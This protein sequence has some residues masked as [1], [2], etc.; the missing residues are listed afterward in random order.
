MLWF[1]V[2]F[3]LKL[4]TLCPE[5]LLLMHRPHLGNLLSCVVRGP[6]GDGRAGGLDGAQRTVCVGEVGRG[7]AGRTRREGEMGATGKEGARRGGDRECYW[8]LQHGACR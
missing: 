8:Q 4:N 7:G 1:I 5:W 3:S 6:L 2:F